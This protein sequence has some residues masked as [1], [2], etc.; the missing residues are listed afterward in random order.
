MWP[1]SRM[2]GRQRRVIRTAR[3]RSSRARSPRPPRSTPER[4]AAE[5][6]AGVVDEDVEPP[7][8]LDRRGDEALAARR[9]GDVELERDVRLEPLD[10][11]RAAGDARARSASA[12][13]VAAPIPLDAPVTIAVLPSSSY[14]ATRDSNERDRRRLAPR[15]RGAWSTCSVVWCRPKR[16]SSSRSSRAARA[17]GS[18]RRARRARARTSAGSRSSPSRRGGRAPRRRR[19]RPRARARPRRVDVPPA[20]LQEDPADSRSSASSTRASARRREARDRVEAV[21]AGEQEHERA[22][23]GRAGERGEVG[24]DVQERAAHVQALAARAREHERRGEVDRD[25]ASATT[26]TMPPRTSGGETSRRIAA[27]DDPDADEQRA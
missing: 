25:A 4:V 6:E 23:D 8:S 3:S 10:A 27:V 13:A 21:P 15:A 5:R 20:S 17:R 7:S 2:C 18:R 19:R 1:P 16:S 11:A 24:R 14:A 12:R 9:V 22:R 26:S